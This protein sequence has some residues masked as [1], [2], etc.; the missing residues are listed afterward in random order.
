ML[1]I[2]IPQKP[3]P[4]SPPK[5]KGY[6]K[7]EQAEVDF[8]K[9]RRQKYELLATILCCA[10]LDLLV[11]YVW[12]FFNQDIPILFSIGPVNIPTSIVYVI[13]FSIFPFPVVLGISYGIVE[14]IPFFNPSKNVKQKMEQTFLRE[15][16]E[17]KRSW[18]ISCYERDMK[19]YNEK[20]LELEKI[21]PGLSKCNYNIS[22]F[23]EMISLEFL[24]NIASVF[25]TSKSLIEHESN[26]SDW[27]KCTDRE[28]EIKTARWYEMCGYKVELTPKSNDGGI[29]VIAKKGRKC[30]YIQCKQY[31]NSHVP[32]S[33]AR[34]LYG[35][36]S[37]NNVTEGAIVCLLGGDKGTLDF[38][39][40]NNIKIIKAGDICLDIT[41][42]INNIEREKVP[43]SL[44]SI[45]KNFMY[46]G[47]GTFEIINEPFS[48]VFS[49]SNY[50]QKNFVWDDNYEF[51]ILLWKKMIY[52]TIRYEKK[53]RK[54]LSEQII[55][56]IIDDK[57]FSFHKIIKEQ[58]NKKSTS[59]KKRFHRK[60]YY[61][62]WY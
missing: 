10:V 61:K 32:V 5:Y 28:F 53:E 52:F 24:S 45:G 23:S 13:L 30:I 60:G 54:Y 4:V 36:M 20:M 25:D 58:I 6:T 3:N 50:L 51:A 17:R 15:E 35:V 7:A 12:Y 40:K 26:I 21:Y 41:K 49:I 46:K 62:K 29:D 14:E 27:L 39:Q 9:K 34:E 18:A 56:Y 57:S 59:E 37:A 8:Y 33:V 43:Y 38:A 31:K 48:D 11:T 44:T 47:Y 22:K 16:E 55:K 2:E 19:D 42:R 1:N